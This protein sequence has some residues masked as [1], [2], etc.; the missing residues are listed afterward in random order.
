MNNRPDLLTENSLTRVFKIYMGSEQT[1]EITLSK[2]TTQMIID[3]SVNIKL[4]RSKELEILSFVL[5]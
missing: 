4:F 2:P 3:P 5:F 1:P